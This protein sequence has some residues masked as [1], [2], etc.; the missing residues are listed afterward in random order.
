MQCDNAELFNSPASSVCGCPSYSTWCRPRLL[1]WL[2]WRAIWPAGQPHRCAT[3][4][5]AA[6]RPLRLYASLPSR[7]SKK[8]H[9]KALLYYCLLQV[10]TWRW[11]RHHCSQLT[12]GIRSQQ[13]RTNGGGKRRNNIKWGNW[14]GCWKT[15]FLDNPPSWGKILMG[16]SKME[17]KVIG[18]IY[19][20]FI[21]VISCCKEKK[22]LW[23]IKKV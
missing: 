11:R 18:R 19:V 6:R 1:A 20:A 15:F 21:S 14:W 9:K 12:I 17:K 4:A 5:P 22:L 2:L 7:R 13:G 8:P 3:E 16:E 23:P 10:A